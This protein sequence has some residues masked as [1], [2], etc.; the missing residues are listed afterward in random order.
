MFFLL[1]FLFLLS[2]FFLFFLS[3][4]LFPPFSFLLFYLLNFRKCIINTFSIDYHL[5]KATKSS[6][7]TLA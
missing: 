2:F 5:W 4:F 1:C 3:F 6:A 7:A